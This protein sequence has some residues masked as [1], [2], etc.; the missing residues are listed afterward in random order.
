MDREEQ[1][2]R[3]K[4]AEKQNQQINKESPVWWKT[5]QNKPNFFCMKKQNKLKTY[6][7]NMDVVAVRSCY[8]YIL[9]PLCANF[10]VLGQKVK[11]N[12]D[13]NVTF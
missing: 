5:K 11:K 2:Q 12:E 7:E 13:N 3:E 1:Q 4:D 9:Y 10:K 6:Q 8:Y